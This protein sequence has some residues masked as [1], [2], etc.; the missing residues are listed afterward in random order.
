MK[1]LAE[2]MA[3]LAELKEEPAPEYIYEENGIAQR[4]LQMREWKR[5]REWYQ[6]LNDENPY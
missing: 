3:R 2:L 1:T 6:E 4:A 5:R